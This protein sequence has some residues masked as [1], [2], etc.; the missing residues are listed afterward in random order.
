VKN[1]QFYYKGDLARY[2]GRS[3]ILYGGKFFQF[4]LLEG[5]DKGQLKLTS[6]CPDC[7]LISGQDKPAN[8]PCHTCE[9][10][11]VKV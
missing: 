4:I 2:T 6:R 7:G 8:A 10:E 1:K 5:K 11:E 9:V 3:E